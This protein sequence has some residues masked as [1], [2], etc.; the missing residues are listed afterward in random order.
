VI[1]MMARATCQGKRGPRPFADRPA[2]GGDDAVPL[3][4]VNLPYFPQ[5]HQQTK[6]ALWIEV[7][8]ALRA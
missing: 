8:R 4:L 2:A 6:K 1:E 5:F 3:H 7:A